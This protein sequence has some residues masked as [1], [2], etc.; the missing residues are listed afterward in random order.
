MRQ[1]TLLSWNIAAIIVGALRISQ[2]VTLTLCASTTLNGATFFALFERSNAMLATRTSM[3]FWN[4]TLVS[5]S[6]RIARSR[7]STATKPV[8]LS[9]PL[10]FSSAVWPQPCRLSRNWPLPS[11]LSSG[12]SCVPG[13]KQ[14]Q[15]LPPPRPKSFCRRSAVS[16]SKSPPLPMVTSQPCV[17][18]TA[19]VA[20]KLSRW[21]TCPLAPISSTRTRCG[22]LA[23]SCQL[24]EASP[25]GPDVTVA[26]AEPLIE[27]LPGSTVARSV[28]PAMP[29]APLTT[30]TSSGNASRAPGAPS[31][32]SPETYRS[33][34][35]AVAQNTTYWPDIRSTRTRCGPGLAPSCQLNAAFPCGSD[36]TVTVA[37][38]EP[39][40]KPLPGWTVAFSTAPAMPSAPLATCT[41]S[42]NAS[43]APGAPSWPSPETYRSMSDAVAQNTTD[44]P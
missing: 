35:D 28:A 6:A 38:A 31:W 11:I 27:P 37:V 20:S 42:G 30:C 24:N 2:P 41:S 32:P 12:T 3:F 29:L 25:C 19:T 8:N 26:V 13:R 17:V 21:M 23:P 14:T 10:R 16:F 33:E 1:S 7:S 43:G 34:S 39:L 15:A 18:A 44:W 40:I 9:G 4:A 5:P 36:V 22:P